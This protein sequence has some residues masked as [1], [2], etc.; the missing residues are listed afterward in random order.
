MNTLL[1]TLFMS[2]TVKFN[3][4][5]GLLSSLCYVESTHNIEAIHHDDG[6]A[7]SLGVCQIKYATAKTLGFKGQPIDLM[8]PKTNIYYAG[9]Y[10]R[11]QLV[12]Y[13]SIEKAVIAYNIG[14]AKSLTTT[15]YQ[16]KVFKRWATYE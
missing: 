8:N 7:D 5:P 13:G 1:V 16:R 10:L 4:P 9:K 2:T 14:S 6:H 11:H 12:R 3:L 15:V